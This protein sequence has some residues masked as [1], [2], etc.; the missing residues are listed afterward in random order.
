MMINTLKVSLIFIICSIFSTPLWAK[1]ESA[2][3]L[4]EEDWATIERNIKLIDN[5]NYMP[6][7][8]PI[9]M[10]NRDALGLTSQQVD[11]FRSWRKKHYVPM[12]N[13]MND[14]IEQRLAFKK[15]SLNPA[16]SNDELFELQTKSLKYQ[17]ELLSIKLSCRKVL[18]EN[19]TEEQW[20][21]FK[22]IVSDDPMIASFIN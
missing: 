12:V 13:I 19:F 11:H 16:I 5:M 18:V 4:S 20:D 3:P 15:A 10:K 22:F 8:L 14:I 7:L 17:K 1:H 2:H 21:N 9:I 6:V